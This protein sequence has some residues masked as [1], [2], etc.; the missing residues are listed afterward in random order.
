MRR[1][2]VYPGLAAGALTV[3]PSKSL[4]HRA[5]IC[6]ALAAG[7]SRLTGLAEETLSADIRATIAGMQKLGA[8]INFVSQADNELVVRGVGGCP[9]MSGD[10]EWEIDCGESGSTLRFLIP[11]A[12][13]SGLPVLLAGHGRLP[14]RPQ[15]VYQ[16]I[17][18]E[19]G[20]C[21]KPTPAQN[22]WLVCGP[23]RPGEFKLRGDISSQFIS[24]LLFALPLLA[25][26]SCLRIEPP[27][28]S[29]SY[30]QLTLATLQK[31]GVAANWQ[32]E[33]TLHIPGSQSYQP[34]RMA[35]EG[36]F[37][38]LAFFAVLGSI[39]ARPEGLEIHGVDVNSA[40]GDRKIIDIIRQMGGDI[41]DLPDGYLVRPAKLRAAQIDLADCPDLGPVLTVLAAHAQGET[42]IYN[43]GRLRIK[44][45]DRIAD[46]QEELQRCGV[47]IRTTDDEMF[48][49]G[50]GSYPGGVCCQAHNDHRIVMALAVLAAA[51]QKPL[52]IAGAEAVN[53]SYPGFF[54]DLQHKLG[55]KADFTEIKAVDEI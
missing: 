34:S 54:A 51:C 47:A 42:R 33:Y 55:I 27:F 45:S 50:G 22:G 26:D 53:K 1:A 52:Q 8:E 15:T 39:S 3:P 43:A 49:T 4:A 35:V 40:Q 25:G 6:A 31:F 5:V 21:F 29:R 46:M 19:Q 12:A 11:I 17:F 7:E 30:V 23:L 37:S 10:V 41:L 32:D 48:I 14:Q 2:T 24:G 28:E 20:L 16:Q 38:Q 44:E 18:A 36:D 9:M 13:L